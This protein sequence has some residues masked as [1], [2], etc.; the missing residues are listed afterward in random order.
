MYLSGI[1]RSRSHHF[2]PFVVLTERLSELPPKVVVNEVE[3]FATP[4]KQVNV[5]E[6]S[7]STHFGLPRDT[8]HAQPVSAG[9]KLNAFFHGT[10]SRGSSQ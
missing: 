3:S 2:I 4:L 7:C 8:V 9:L 6:G 10:G 1:Y 5:R